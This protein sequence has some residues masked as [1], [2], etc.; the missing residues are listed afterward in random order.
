MNATVRVAQQFPDVKFEHC[1]G[2]KTADNLAVYNARFYEGRTVIGHIAGHMSKSGTVGY[3]VSFPIPEVVMGINA[4]FLARARSTP[5]S[6]QDRVGEQLVRSGQ[7]GGRGQDPDRPG[8]RHHRPAHR[9]PGGAA[10]R[11]GARRSR[12]RPGLRHE[13]VRA[14]RPA[15]RDRRQLGPYYV[16]RVKAVQAGTWATQNTWRGLKEG[17]VEI[18]PYGRRCPRR[19]RS[20]PIRS[21]TR[22]SPASCT[23]SPGR[24]TTRRRARPGGGR[25]HGGRGHP[26]HGLL[27]AGHRGLA[28]DVTAGDLDRQRRSGPSA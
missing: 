5:T 28:A 18:A 17:M 2:Y 3:I 21:R 14:E 1:T 24:S 10:G 13:Q 20:R 27:R 25:N 4:F 6:S 7:G 8:R 12:L 9:Q 19:W 22:S 11:R 26:A 16:E 15:D 23:R